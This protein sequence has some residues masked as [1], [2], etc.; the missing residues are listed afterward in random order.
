ME[1]TP[2]TEIENESKLAF[3]WL[4]WLCGGQYRGEP[5]T[6]HRGAWGRLCWPCWMLGAEAESE[7][8]KERRNKRIE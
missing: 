1:Q 3:P 2:E 6:A 5:D 4:C 7:E 8:E